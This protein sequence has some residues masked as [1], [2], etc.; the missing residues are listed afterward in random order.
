LTVLGFKPVW[1]KPF[2]DY[3][4]NHFPDRI[5]NRAQEQFEQGICTPRTQ[6]VYH[7]YM[8]REEEGWELTIHSKAMSAPAVIKGLDRDTALGIFSELDPNGAEVTAEAI[9]GGL[10]WRY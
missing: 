5:R 9:R 2:G 4:G 6:V 3:T 10:G 1:G 8:D 7:C